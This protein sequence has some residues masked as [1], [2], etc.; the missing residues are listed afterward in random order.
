MYCTA[1]AVNF[2][3]YSWQHMPASGLP[4]IR[5]LHDDLHQSRYLLPPTTIFIPP[6]TSLPFL[7]VQTGLAIQFSSQIPHFIHKGYQLEHVVKQERRIASSWFQVN[8]K[9]IIGVSWELV[10]S[11]PYPYVPTVT[12]DTGEIHV[13]L[14]LSIVPWCLEKAM[15]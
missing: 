15:H 7:T 5:D 12:V 3:F 10:P 2:H 9:I 13:N 6:P 8:R 14:Y 1:A 4:L 11:L